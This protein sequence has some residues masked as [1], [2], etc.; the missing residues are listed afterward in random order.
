MVVRCVRACMQQYKH[1][2]HVHAES[3]VPLFAPSR[4]SATPVA[5][6]CRAP[7]VCVS[8]APFPVVF[9][10]PT[11]FD[12][13]LP[14]PP[15]AFLPLPWVREQQTHVRRRAAMR[16]LATTPAIPA[17]VTSSAAKQTIAAATM[18]RCVVPNVMLSLTDRA[19]TF[20]NTQMHAPTD[21][22]TCIYPTEHPLFSPPSS[23]SASFLLRLLPSPSSSLSAFFPLIFH[24]N[25]PFVPALPTPLSPRFLFSTYLYPFPSHPSLSLSP[26]LSS[27]SPHFPLTLLCSWHPTIAL[28]SQRW[29]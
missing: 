14:P 24:L 22:Y 19:H 9:P 7:A 10:H 26:S 8:C 29:R 12:P 16:F 20:T 15:G 11:P 27:L 2:T 1:C 17:S 6:I 3:S 4:L 5:A 25:P 28:H 23:L 13:I 21:V 18:C